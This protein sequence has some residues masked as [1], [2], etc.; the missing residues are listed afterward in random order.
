MLSGT[1]KVFV[2]RWIY[3]ESYRDPE[4]IRVMEKALGNKTC[5]LNDAQLFFSVIG[6]DLFTEEEKSYID[7]IGDDPAVESSLLVD[8]QQPSCFLGALQKLAIERIRTKL[9]RC[10]DPSNQNTGR[11]LPDKPHIRQLCR[12]FNR[13]IRK[14]KEKDEEL[15]H[16]L[17]WIQDVVIPSLN[18]YQA[19][20]GLSVHQ[21]I[22][23]FQMLKNSQSTC[24]ELL[25]LNVDLT[26]GLICSRFSPL[27]IY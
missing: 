22:K 12:S 14:K 8:G 7:L 3:L 18:S 15:L 6:Y 9:V 10:F 2:Q 21:L 5:S 16:W 11:S 1:R 25:Q 20:Q 24:A 27:R 26:S 19:H 17:L 13:L 23:F 4:C